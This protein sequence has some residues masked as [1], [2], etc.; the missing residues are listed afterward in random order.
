MNYL[1]PCGDA[2]IWYQ[3]IMTHDMGFI[4]RAV[5]A[6]IQE[7]YSV[8]TEVT[9]T[10]YG[11]AD[12]V[13]GSAAW[14]VKHGGKRTVER[15]VE[16]WAQVLVYIML[17]DEISS[18]GPAGAFSG[19][20]SVSYYGVPAHVEYVTPFPGVVLYYV[21][22]APNYQGAYY[23]MVSKA[24]RKDEKKADNLN[25]VLGGIAAVAGVTS[26]GICGGGSP[27]YGGTFGFIP[28]C[29]YSLG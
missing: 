3:L 14:E 1:D 21:Q 19:S 6:H 8:N 15:T 4:H 22:G 26:I 9:L 25:R 2:R 27:T 12:I 16:A 24:D 23:R 17:N 5:V 13:Q 7:N 20:L 18:H 29:A 28:K 10:N 11:R